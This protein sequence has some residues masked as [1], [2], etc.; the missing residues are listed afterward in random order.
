MT[1][2]GIGAGGRDSDQLRSELE[3]LGIRPPGRVRYN[4]P[5]PRLVELSLARGEG[6]LA[7]NGALVVLT[8]KYTGRS[9]RDRF[10][11]DTPS[12]HDRIHWSDYNQPMERDRFN[13]ILDRQLE[14]LRG[15]E[16]FIVDAF[17]G[18]D[19]AYRVAVRVVTELA[20]QSL[21][22]RQLLIKA[23]AEELCRHR[24]EVVVL[25]TPRL[26]AVPAR[27]GTHSECVIAL[28]LERG[29]ISVVASGYAGEIKKALFSYMNYILPEKGV[30]PMHCAANVGAGGDVALFFGLSGTGK[31]TLSS[32]PSRRIIGDDEHGWSE[33]GVFNYEGG[34]YAKCIRLSPG[35]E[36]CIFN[37]I[38]FGAV[39]ENA[40]LDEETRELRYGD[41][42][43]TENTRAGYPLEHLPGAVS[44]AA[45]GHPK[46]IVFL[47]ADAF[48]VL[49]PV[50]VLSREG[51]IYHFLSGYTSKLAGTE[52]GVIV[53]R[54]TFSACFGAPFMPR[55]PL[56]YAGQLNEWLKRYEV[57]TY[58]VNTGWTG[59]P[60]GEGKRIPLEYTRTI[61]SS[62]LGNG[63]RGVPCRRDPVFN[64]SVPEECEG[65]PGE[66]LRPRELWRSGEAYDTMA[67]KLAWWFIE[68]FRKFPGAPHRVAEAGPRIRGLDPSPA[69]PP[70]GRTPRGFEDWT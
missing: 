23:G 6:K 63:L 51:A 11:V 32:D 65:V 70:G 35:T 68:N 57:A 14:H 48:G 42:S 29:I 62:A 40:V 69:V 56:F 59:G 16:L 8:G 41:D 46:A 1:E 19:P 13:S 24:P 45:A 17:L 22:A 15:R 53:P 52:R 9:P 50:A 60:Y 20:W 44:P 12:V 43:I 66:L 30:F 31:T 67:V 55:S 28:E 21:F 61:V 7:G 39:V 25:S 26:R 27:D 49:P 2:K 58:L 18:A 38:K 37:A 64:L 34:C 36:P 54:A 5:V 47:T 3:A 4:L 10:I 33:R